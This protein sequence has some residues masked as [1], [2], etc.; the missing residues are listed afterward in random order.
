MTGK[1]LKSIR[2]ALGLSTKELGRAFGYR[3]ND[4]TISVQVRAYESGGRE[5]PPWIERLAL[6]FKRHGVPSDWC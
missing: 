4:N 5:I 6:M 3:G 1:E 2:K